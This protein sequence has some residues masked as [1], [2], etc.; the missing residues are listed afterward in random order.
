MKEGI[1]IDLVFVV[2]CIAVG[3][4]AGTFGSLVGLGGGVIII[5]SLLYLASVHPQFVHVTPAVAAGS[6]LV[7]VILTA[8]S[9]TISYGRQKRI[10]F[11]VGG[12]LAL[13]CAPGALIGAIFT[14][15]FSP[16]RFS[17][18]FALLMFLVAYLLGLKKKAPQKR[19]KWSVT[20]TVVIDGQE[21]T[22][23]YQ[24]T[25]ALMISFFVG[26]LCGMFGIGGGS[27]LV[28][29]MILLFG[30][31]PHLAAATSMFTILLTSTLGSVSHVWQGNVNW[32]IVL[33]MAPGSWLGGQLGV[34][35][36]NRLSSKRLLIVLRVAFVLV[37]IRML[38]EGIHLF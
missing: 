22:Y 13:A 38:L 28:P 20:R 25:V 35:I 26:L 17:L 3:L 34:W 5:P 8:L 10:D 32:W 12:I 31:P 15:F 19:L 4:L 7:L 11:Q 16:D 37:A 9:S 29:M 36:S 24:R 23:G 2:I 27:L 21:V 30:F 18:F 6:S 1:L 33:T 14:R